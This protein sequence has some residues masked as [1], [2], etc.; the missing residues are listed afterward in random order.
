LSLNTPTNRRPR[1]SLRHDLRLVA[2]L[3]YRK[4]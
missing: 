3:A 1:R 2:Q 4:S